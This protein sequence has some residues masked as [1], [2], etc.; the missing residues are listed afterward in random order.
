M[1][2]LTQMIR[3]LISCSPENTRRNLGGELKDIQ[4]WPSVGNPCA[5]FR[6]GKLVSGLIYEE[7]RLYIHEGVD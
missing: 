6:P 5:D 4:E 3:Y 2:N 7:K 1:P